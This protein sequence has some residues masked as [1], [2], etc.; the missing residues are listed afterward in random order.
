MNIRKRW[1][2]AAAIAAP[3]LIAVASAT[4]ATAAPAH[5]AHPATAHV[6]FTGDCNCNLQSGVAPNRYV[7][8][9]SG[10]YNGAQMTMGSSRGTR[11]NRIDFYNDGGDGYYEY[12]DTLTGECLKADPNISGAPVV[13]WTC[14]TGH[15]DTTAE[16]ELFW[17]TY[18]NGNYWEWQLLYNRV[19]LYDNE[20]LLWVTS[21][22]GN[23]A[24]SQCEFELSS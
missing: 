15:S 22:T 24:N 17:G 7:M 2:T 3:L 8:R 13:E 16:E 23:C 21:G 14:E 6:A 5:P 4:A 19:W 1:V 10:N 11:F 9:A 20:N 18:Q 12:Q